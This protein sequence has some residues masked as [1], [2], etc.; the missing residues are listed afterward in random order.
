MVDVA[1]GCVRGLV[2]VKE[3]EEYITYGPYVHMRLCTRKLG[4]RG[5]S[6][7]SRSCQ[8]VE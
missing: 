7:A 1:L 3:S 4:A 6:I 5:I 8:G 2:T